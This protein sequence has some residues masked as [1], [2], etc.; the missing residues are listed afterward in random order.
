MKFPTVN[1]NGTDKRDLLAGYINAKRSLAQAIRD[2][3]EIAPHGRDYQYVGG[4]ADLRV[5]IEEHAKRIVAVR[6]VQI[7]IEQLAEHVI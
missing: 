5:A 6:H 4:D 2:L 3:Q 7:E 1:I